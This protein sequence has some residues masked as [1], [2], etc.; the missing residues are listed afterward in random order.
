MDGALKRKIT[1][2]ADKAHAAA[3]H[4]S[5]QQTSQR[6]RESTARLASRGVILSGQTVLW[7]ARWE[8]PAVILAGQG[9]SRL[10]FREESFAVNN[11]PMKLRQVTGKRERSN[12]RFN[13][14]RQS[15]AF[16]G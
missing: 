5:T 15:S 16:S 9:G 7:G 13:R 12:V 10:R 4:T 11:L 14:V 1:D 3:H 2:Y 6:I 8:E